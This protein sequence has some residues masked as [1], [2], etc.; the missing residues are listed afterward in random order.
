M[1]AVSFAIAAVAVL[2]IVTNTSISKINGTIDPQEN[3]QYLI[4]KPL[5]AFRLL[6]Q[7]INE[8]MFGVR[9]LIS[10]MGWIDLNLSK[11]TQNYWLTLCTASVG[12][13]LLRSFYLHPRYPIRLNFLRANLST[14][15]LF[16]LLGASLMICGSA[17][18]TSLAMYLCCTPI[19]YGAVYAVQNRYF[20]PYWIAIFSVAFGLLSRYLAS[21][22]SARLV[23]WFR[24]L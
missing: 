16:K 21:G 15:K 3:L 9:G 18:R 7:S 24:H 22:S 4:N 10:P 12:I 6:N 19:N 13:D 2:A 11:S 1:A 5:F 8:R 17:I 20:F 23:A 14:T